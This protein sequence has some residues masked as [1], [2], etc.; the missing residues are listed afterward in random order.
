LLDPDLMIR[1][2]LIGYLYGIPE[3]RLIEEVHLNLAYRWFCGLGLA[4][5]VPERSSFSKTM[6]DSAT[7]MLSVCCS[8][9]CCKA[10]FV[11]VWSAAR[12]SPRIRV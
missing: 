12:R 5:D 9:M 2:L 3:R 4:G 11:P 1:M 8:G 10:V 6:D 7:A